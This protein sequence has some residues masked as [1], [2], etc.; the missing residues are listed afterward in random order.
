MLATH[1]VGPRPRSSSAGRP[2]RPDRLPTRTSSFPEPEAPGAAVRGGCDDLRAG[3]PGDRP[4][5]WEES[6]GSESSASG[7]APYQ[8]T[9]SGT[10]AAPRQ[11]GPDPDPGARRARDR[12]RRRARPG[13]VGALAVPGRG[14]AR[15]RGARPGQVRRR[16]DRGQ[17][18]RRAQ[19]ARRHRHDPGPDRRT[20]AVAVLPAVGGR[21]GLRPGRRPAQ[22]HARAGRRR[23]RGGGARGARASCRCRHRTAGGPAVRARPPAGQPL[24]GARL[25]RRL[26]EPRPGP[27][28]G[29]LGAARPA[30][31]LVRGGRQ[32]RLDD[33]AAARAARGDAAGR[34]PA[35]EAP[36][37]GRRR[38]R[39]RSP[40]LPA[41]RRARPRQDRPGPAR[42]PRPPTPSRCSRSCPTW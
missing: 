24:P 19:A 6:S 32:R 17:A 39:R 28:A 8:R 7:V 23:G 34:A 1:K 40:H 36:G 3:R 2:G 30:V 14:A 22:G 18:R 20:R 27:A 42:P 38:G 41:R 13:R 4:G 9:R 29:R 33:D 37:R 16:P 26:P 10:H 21:Q 25:H 5:R 35:D 12:V 31:P 11:R 15:P